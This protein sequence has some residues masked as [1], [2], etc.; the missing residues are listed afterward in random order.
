MA[1]SIGGHSMIQPNW[2]ASGEPQKKSKKTPRKHQAWLAAHRLLVE[3][4]KRGI[5]CDP[6]KGLFFV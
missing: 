5:N 3:R 6:E 2:Q 1:A 4:L